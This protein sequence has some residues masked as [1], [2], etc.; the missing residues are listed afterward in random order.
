[1]EELKKVREGKTAEQGGQGRISTTDPEARIMKNSDG[2]YEPAYNVQI[3]TDGS[4]G[5]IVDITAVQDYNDWGQLIPAV[6]R[7]EATAGKPEQVIVDAGYT[8][9][10]N[11]EAIA[12]KQIG[13]IGPVLTAASDPH[14]Y[15][16]RGISA[17]FEVEAFEFDP[18]AN[19]Y[20]CPAGKTLKLTT[21]QRH[22][23]RMKWKY[24]ARPS[25][26]QSCRLRDECCPKTR[27]RRITRSEDSDVVRAFQAKM[28][29]EEAQQIYRRR[30]Q[31]AEF[32]NAWIK[33]KLGLRQFRLRGLWKVQMECLWVGLTYNIQQWIRL[34]WRRQCAPVA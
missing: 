10:E 1:M 28:Q 25:D 21:K 7:V 26:C 22:A 9:R 2:G 8:R 14:H 15:A 11:I 20:I 27:S 34:S 29:T 5:V 33:E 24:Q 18:A 23:G 30:P 6:E 19:H 17:N 12:E 16:E 4:H 31:I 13:M 3:S 32:V